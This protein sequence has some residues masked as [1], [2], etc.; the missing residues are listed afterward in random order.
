MLRGHHF[1]CNVKQIETVDLWEGQKERPILCH[2]TGRANPSHSLSQV[3]YDGAYAGANNDIFPRPSAKEI[4]TTPS[5][6]GVSINAS[7]PLVS[8]LIIN[9][10]H[11]VEVSMMLLKRRAHIRHFVDHPE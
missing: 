1:W 5:N 2:C 10:P 9:L 3:Q 7:R 8:S 11:L 6:R 4:E